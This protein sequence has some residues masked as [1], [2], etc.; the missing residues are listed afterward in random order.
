MNIFVIAPRGVDLD[1]PR[2]RNI[3]ERAAADLEVAITIPSYGAADAVSHSISSPLVAADAV[4]ADLSF[5]R[6]SSYYEL[7]VAEALDKTVKAV[8]RAG[9]PIHQTQHRQDVM[10]YETLEDYDRI[11]RQVFQD[12]RSASRTAP[13][14]ALRRRRPS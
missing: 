8:A 4:L 9:T 2:K 6:P 1:W 7:G 12:L 10:M 5:E 3:L 11:I 14:P 13:S